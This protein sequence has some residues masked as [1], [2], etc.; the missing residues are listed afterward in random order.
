MSESE[1][2]DSEKREALAELARVS[3]DNL[4]NIFNSAPADLSWEEIEQKLAQGQMLKD[5]CG[6]DPLDLEKNYQEG[7]Q[8]LENEDYE[9]AK[10]LFTTLCLYDQ[11]TAK[12]WAG[13]ALCCENLEYYSE[14]IE[15]YKMLTLVTGGTNI[16]PYV[17]MGYCYLSLGDKEKAKEVLEVGKEIGD[18]YDEDNRE[19]LDQ[20]DT[21]LELCKAED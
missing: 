7:K 5:I 9:G 18:P 6:I 2:T 13:L 21:M 3:V 20:L 17:C 11:S 16:M 4:K 12:Y 15:C 8:K 1:L 10:E 19:T 14:A